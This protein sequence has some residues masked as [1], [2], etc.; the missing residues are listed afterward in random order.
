MNG[1]AMITAALLYTIGGVF[2][3]FSEGFSQFIPSLLVYLLFVIGASLEIY[4]MNNAHLGVTSFLVNGLD[5][6][7]TILFSLL[8]FRESYTVF[9]GLGVLLIIIGT[10]FLR[11]EAG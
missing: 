8:V 9:T 11:A 6:T 10:A 5:A 4:V 1:W 2:M 7:W 3:K